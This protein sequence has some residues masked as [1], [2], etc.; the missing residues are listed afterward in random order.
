MCTEGA[1]QFNFVCTLNRWISFN[2]H[3]LSFIRP[4]F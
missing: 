4:C 1:V 2:L 3:C